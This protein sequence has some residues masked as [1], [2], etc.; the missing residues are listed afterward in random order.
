V[1]VGFAVAISVSIIIAIIAI[2]LRS[3]NNSSNRSLSST[4][5]LLLL[6][7]IIVYGAGLIYLRTHTMI[8]FGTIM[9]VPIFPEVIPLSVAAVTR[10]RCSPSKFPVQRVVS[11]LTTVAVMAY[12]D[13]NLYDICCSSYIPPHVALVSFLADPL[14]DGVPLRSWFAKNVP[15]DTPVVAADGQATAYVLH[16]PTISIAPRQFSSRIWDENQ[17]RETMSTYHAKYLIT[18]S[19]LFSDDAPE[20]QQSPFLRSLIAGEHHSSLSPVVRTPHVTIFEARDR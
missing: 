18:Y 20:Q 1:K 6:I 3:G 7:I 17:V 15:T 5:M 19:G 2:M 11:L 16:R 12:G 9:F 8:T 14:P 13:Q 4:A 10:F